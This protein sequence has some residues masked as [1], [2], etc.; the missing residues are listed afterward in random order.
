MSEKDVMRLVYEKYDEHQFQ[1]YVASKTVQEHPRLVQVLRM[2]G[3]GKRLL[4]IGVSMGDFG[5]FLTQHGNT[6]VGLDISSKAVE[7]CQ[8]RGLEAF[9]VNVETE[10]LPD[11]G[12]FDGVLLLEIIEHLI[13]PLLVLQKIHDVLYPSGFILI[14]TPNA[15]YFKWRLRLLMGAMPDFGENRAN[16]QIPRPY[17]LLHKTPLTVPDLEKLLSLA[18]FS[19]SQIEPEDYGISKKWNKPVLKQCRQWIRQFWPTMFAGSVV[20]KAVMQKSS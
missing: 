3:S 15:A 6:V 7:I 12:K 18:D 11:I 20:A 4:E 5:L 19:I 10:S 2:I 8:A 13:D 9:R 17:N 1:E 16:A 14:S